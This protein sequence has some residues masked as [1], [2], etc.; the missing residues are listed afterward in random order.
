M[1]MS[2]LYNKPNRNVTK[3]LSEN[4]ICIYGSC[5]SLLKIVAAYS[6]NRGNSNKSTL[7]FYFYYK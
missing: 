3:G 1:F 7:I 2:L 6:D 5:Y 4:Y